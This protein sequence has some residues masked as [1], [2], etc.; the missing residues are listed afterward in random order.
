MTN[1]QRTATVG[2]GL[3]LLGACGGSRK[4]AERPNGTTATS[5]IGSAELDRA[6]SGRMEDLLARVPGLE[7]ARNGG[8]IS[9][10]IRGNLSGVDPLV[11][12]DG[13]QV[14]QGGVSSMLSAMNPQDVARVQVLKDA[15]STAIYGSAGVNGVVLITTKRGKK[16]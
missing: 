8:E 1:I 4:P 3:V 16:P 2:L 12:V 15:G 5:T 6:Q 11:V 9:L 14:R 13:M 10:R 7:V